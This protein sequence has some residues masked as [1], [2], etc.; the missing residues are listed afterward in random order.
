MTQYQRPEGALSE[1]AIARL[2]RQV[3]FYIQ[4]L[5]QDLAGARAT[6][7]AGPADSDTFADSYGS[8][9]RPLGRSTDVRFGGMGFDSTFNVRMLEGELY[10]KGNDGSGERMIVIPESANSVR[11]GFVPRKGRQVSG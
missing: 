9:P 4:R 1:D 11:L 3:R 8:T 6:L 2:P 7:A 5:E 10:V